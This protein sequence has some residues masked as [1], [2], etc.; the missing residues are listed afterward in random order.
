MHQPAEQ[1]KEQPASALASALLKV[2]HIGVAVVRRQPK[3]RKRCAQPARVG[4]FASRW[5]LAHLW[6]RREG[7]GPGEG[8]H[9][10]ARSLAGTPGQGAA[11]G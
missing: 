8:E 9:V 2:G 3:P 1:P 6:H 5:Q 7:A 11:V 10:V 4:P